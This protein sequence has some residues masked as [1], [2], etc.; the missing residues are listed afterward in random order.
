VSAATVEQRLDGATF[1]V[2]HHEQRR[3]QRWI[4]RVLPQ[5]LGNRNPS[6]GKRFDDA[7]LS[8]HI[9]VRDRLNAWR[10]ELD[11]HWPAGSC[12]SEGEAGRTTGQRSDVGDVGSCESLSQL[13]EV[14]LDHQPAG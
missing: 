10:G 8:Q 4:S 1:D 14:D 11:H 7:S 5:H 3:D 6:S 12:A 13:V 9:P 2:G